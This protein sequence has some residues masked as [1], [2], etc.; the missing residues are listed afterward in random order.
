MQILNMRAVISHGSLV[1]GQ[2]LTTSPYNSR[3]WVQK[4]IAREKSS[5]CF[6][7]TIAC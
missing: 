6:R 3:V 2:E 5:Y 1:Q 7:L 4:E